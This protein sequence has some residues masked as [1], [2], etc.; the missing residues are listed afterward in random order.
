MS[1]RST[2]LSLVSRC[3]SEFALLRH[4]PFAH[5]TDGRKG[6]RLLR[7]ER[8][9]ETRY[10]LRPVA[11]RRTRR[12]VVMELD[13]VMA[14]APHPGLVG[15]GGIAMV[16]REP[17]RHIIMRACQPQ[18]PSWAVVVLLLLLLLLCASYVQSEGRQGK[19]FPCSLSFGRA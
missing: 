14:T 10:P 4:A 11:P 18:S 17:T 3:F 8:F 12:A 1:L 7:C 9:A 19:S 16:T 15:A 13:V 5:I 2:Y 6:C